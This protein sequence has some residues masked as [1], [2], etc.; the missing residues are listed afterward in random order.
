MLAILAL[1]IT[2]CAVRFDGLASADVSVNNGGVWVLNN[3]KHLLGRVNVDAQELDAR[4]SIDGENLDVQQDGYNVL[5]SGP[6]GIIPVDSAAVERSGTINL[7]VDPVVDLGGD[8]VGM[9]GAKGKVWVADAGQLAGF[10]PSA[11][12]P[13]LS[14]EGENAKLAVTD[15]GTVYVL[16]GDDLYKIPR[17][18]D[19][20]ASKP[21]KVATIDGLSTTDGAVQLTTVGESPVVL[22][23]ESR[24]LRIGE[25]GKTSVSLDDLGASPSSTTKA[26]LQQPGP[27]ADGVVLATSDTLYRV[28]LSGKAGATEKHSAH[29][30]GEP[31]APA[32]VGGCA[33]G[34][35]NG[36][37]RYVRA[38][39]GTVTAEA[40]PDARDANDLKLRVN[41]DL[42]V[43][44]DQESGLSWMISEDMT[45]V[46]DW[47]V[48]QDIKKDE[49][50]QEEK[51]TK[52]S[53]VA[54]LDYDRKEKNRD[55]VAN[56]DELGVR[57][58]SSTVLDV[59][60]NDTDP[61]GDVL[62]AAPKKDEGPLGRVTPIRGGT[63]L[64]I[65]VP[66]DAKPGT[67]KDVVYSVAD[68]R[69]GT[70]ESTVTLKVKDEGDS[71]PP[72]LSREETPKMKVRSGRDFS[73]NVLPYFRDPDGDD[74]YLAG[75]SVDGEDSV[76]STPD[77]VVS[78][79]D[80][81]LADGEKSISL[82]L[83]DSTGEEFTSEL[84][85]EVV[86]DDD[87]P[88]ITTADHTQIVAGSTVDLEPLENDLSPTGD[89]L[90]LADVSVEGGG[91]GIELDKDLDAGTVSVTGGQEGTYYLRYTVVA[92]SQSATGL[93]RVDVAEPSSEAELPVAVDDLSMV[94]AGSSTLVDPLENDVDP[95]GGV[96]VL[97][98]V[99]LPEDSGLEARVLDHHL[100]KLTAS[101]D[102]PTDGRPVPI[103]YTVANQAGEVE[104]SLQA[105]IVKTDTQ[106]AEP[107]AVND[108]VTVRAGDLV[109]ADVLANDT[110]PIDSDLSLDDDFGDEKEA[111]GLG[112]LETYQDKVRFT[113]DP[114]AKGETTVSYTA[115]DETGRTGAARLRM[116]VVPADGNNERPAP[117]NLTARTVAGSSVRIPVSLSG[118]DP[119]GD[120]VI[121]TGLTGDAPTKGRVT[122]ATGQWIDY[123]PDENATGTDTF[124]YQVMDRDG[125][126]GTAEVKVGIAARSQTNQYPVS[127]DDEVTAKPGR[128]LQIFP[129]ENDSDPEGA[130]LSIDRGMVGES[131]EDEDSAVEIQ[132]SAKGAASVDVVTPEEPGTYSIPYGV[133]DGS[134]ST[135]GTILLDVKEDAP[136][137]S[138]IVTDDY[139]PTA[140][141]LDPDT[142]HVDVDALSNDVDPDGS[143][144]DLDLE[145]EGNPDGV[146]IADEK[147]G[148]VRVTPR[149]DPFRV[150]YTA[151]D[152]DDHSASGYIWVPGTSKQAPAWVG[153]PITV[154]AGTE[155]NIDLGD[156][157]LVRVRPGGQSP[158]ITDPDTVSAQH[159]DGS[160][161]IKDDK[162][163][164]YRAAEDYSG[165]DTINVEVTDGPRGDDTAA[166]GMLAIPVDVQ[167]KDDAPPEV[168]GSDLEVEQGGDARTVDLRRTNTDP[169]GKPLTFEAGE[170]TGADG[171]SVDVTSEGMVTAQ[172]DASVDKGASFEVPVTVSD[173]TNDPVETTIT[174]TVT[175]S[176]APKATA[177]DDSYR[178]DAGDTKTVSPTDN[179]T[180]PLGKPVHLVS[181][182]P[183]TD[184]IEATQKG[185]EV[186]LAPAEDFHGVATVSYTVEDATK[187]PDRRTTGEITVDVRGKPEKPSA[188]RVSETG[189]GFVVLS[190]EPGDDNGAP[191]EDYTVSSASGGSVK[192]T[193]KSTTC[194]VTGLKNDTE[195]TFTA[196]ANNEVGP[197]DPSA[198]SAKARPDVKP[199]KPDAP[200]AERGDGRL[201]VSWDAP[202]N[203]GSAITEYALQMIGKDGSTRTVPVNGSATSTT[204]D[205]LTNGVD[206]TFRVRAKNRAD[207]PSDWSGSS[208]P[209]HPAGKPTAP[210]GKITAK[211]VNDELGGAVSLSWP[212][213]SGKEQN[214]EKVT[215]YTVTAHPKDGGGSSKSQTFEDTSGR[216]DGLDQN[217]EYTFTYMGTNSVG[218]G[219]AS[220]ESNPVTAYSKA[221]APKNVSASLP[222]AKSG[223]GPNGRVNVSWDKAD[224]RGT[225]LDHYLVRWP[226]GGS[227]EVDAS[228]DSVQIDGLKNGTDYTFTVQAYNRFSGGESEISKPSK[229]VRPYTK[230][231]KP[232]L[233]LSTGDCSGTSCP[234]SA[235]VSANG[236]GGIGVSKVQ[237]RVNGGDWKDL[238]ADGGSAELGTEGGK[239]YTVDA[240]AI[241]SAGLVSG[242]ASANEKSKSP[243]PKLS[244]SVKWGAKNGASGEIG[245]EQG[246]CRWFSFTLENMEPGKSYQ[247]DF[248]EY[249]TSSKWSD[250]ASSLPKSVS[251]NGDGKFT[252]EN[253]Y[254]HGYPGKKFDV[255]LD[256]KKVATITEPES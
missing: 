19:P 132:D 129:L 105:M 24:F 122:S 143:A 246:S 92:G 42:V 244:D 133:S 50:E 83:R 51:E 166:V 134:L 11:Q 161:L 245:C 115:R 192:Q 111:E 120:S 183:K 23:T 56:P 185:D 162:H 98:S 81:G 226:G 207:D 31:T 77:G 93:I 253:R 135:P 36:S 223:D 248:Y 73:F 209:E 140:E 187:D 130:P 239:K 171:V 70:A 76:T 25:K 229:A 127:E 1:V 37:Q 100:I 95:T 176:N 165:E 128:K 218:E 71:A 252:S 131:E 236:G 30:N 13:T 216:F 52:T 152:L 8:R 167:A 53:T 33:Y 232:A 141:V 256:G 38:C 99:D 117:E 94:T 110:S 221:A 214:G 231:A 230:P 91:D 154:Q 118:V 213:M 164:V 123:T 61:D 168:Q 212:A 156:S 179:D 87:L 153:D 200:H 85:V 46:D 251:A 12:K 34:A 67:T 145:I 175:G 119:D 48:T 196:R 75:A 108:D 193:C 211:R 189:D 32:Q 68:G 82:T 21:E 148:I 22:D 74:F 55:P 14:V 96:L 172:A 43:L 158:V 205:D 26:Q 201:K 139:V 62:T 238:G 57:P 240:R 15:S 203:R 208:S 44:N 90:E 169:E 157:D 58:G 16:D 121:L 249:E 107:K 2:I 215:K 4:E 228:K 10:S 84:K 237:Y 124:R 63:Q 146:R 210:S 234:V 3:G 254:F 149:E 195:Y 160:S 188:P 49:R 233:S 202:V 174:G 247:L 235:K 78:Y 250:G 60:R 186:T 178:V 106:R 89:D 17:S 181:V 222:D 147:R 9:I 79:T 28:P 204:V 59:L 180:K 40:I 20:A 47:V 224:G 194:K 39:G 163:L 159:S 144:K 72:E 102:A 18:I 217:T 170:P 136:E 29:G 255:L 109:T 243:T 137:R 190:I 80:A 113:A 184:G 225:P 5:V 242:T 88:P 69:G 66:E 125:A 126:V 173:G 27:D 6:R 54:N 241:N 219:G 101:P 103:S 220:G 197:S 227:K 151:T 86:P 116:N 65:D 41:G 45:L 177:L 191:I 104:G 114:D 198:A 206:Y 138:P 150:R 155:T 7:G 112:T 142:D 35:W 199:E 182:S 97:D 64:Q